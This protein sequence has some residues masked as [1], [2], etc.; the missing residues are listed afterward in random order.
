MFAGV[1]YDEA[2][3]ELVITRDEL[4]KASLYWGRGHDGAVWVSS[5]M[6]AIQDVCKE[7]HIFPPGSYVKCNMSVGVKDSSHSNIQVSEGRW[8]NA[9]WVEED[10]IPSQPADLKLIHD[11][12]V[13]SVVKR[14]MTDVPFGVLLS[15]ERPFDPCPYGVHLPSLGRPGLGGIRGQA[16]STRVFLPSLSWET[17]LP[18]GARSEPGLLEPAQPPGSPTWRHPALRRC[19]PDTPLS[20]HQAA[21]TRRWLPRSRCA[22]C[23]SLATRS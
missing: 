3:G 4:G 6:K 8:Y 19:G 12:L 1:C 16:A 9:P 21:S 5:E 14:L 20:S 7:F 18:W 15:G 11:T 22:T 13:R 2:K 10:R 23:G 17:T